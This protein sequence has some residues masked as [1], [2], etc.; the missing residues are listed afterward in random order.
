V[1]YTIITY[2]QNQKGEYQ[3]V[4]RGVIEREPLEKYEAS[5][6]HWYAGAWVKVE[7]L[8][9]PPTGQEWRDSK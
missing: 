4:S 2:H 5:G 1:T 6:T 3:E 8:A 7:I 9:A